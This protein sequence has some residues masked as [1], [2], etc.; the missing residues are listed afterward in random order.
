MAAMTQRLLKVTRLIL[1]LQAHHEHKNMKIE[2]YRADVTEGRM[3]PEKDKTI[4]PFTEKT[5]IKKRI[6]RY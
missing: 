2:K 4:M 1:R 6:R 5:Q 3:M